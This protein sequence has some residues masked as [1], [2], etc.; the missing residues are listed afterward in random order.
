M[1]LHA[2]SSSAS[3]ATGSQPLLPSLQHEQVPRC[4]LTEMC[5]DWPRANI[6]EQWP[7]PVAAELATFHWPLRSVSE[8]RRLFECHHAAP[9]SVCGGEF[10]AAVRSENERVHREVTISADHRESLIPGVHACM[11]MRVVLNMRSRASGR[12]PW[13]RAYLFPPCTHQTL[14]DT[15]ARAA[16][17]LDGRRFWGILFVIWCWCVN[18]IMIMV[19]QPDTV[20]P[21][22]YRPPTQR[23]RTSE[24]G[25]ADDKP[26]NLYERGRAPLAPVKAV[27]GTSGH[28]R[29]RDFADAE[30]RDRWRSSWARFPHTVR[31]VVAAEHD[32]LPLATPDFEEERERFAV[33]CYR[34]G[35]HVPADYE[36]RDAQ[37]SSM[38]DRAYQSTRGLGDGR[39]PAATL[40]RS[41]REDSVLASAPADLTSMDIAALD[42]RRVDL[43]EVNPNVILLCFVIMQTTPLILA[44]LNGF[45]VIGADFR[46]ETHRSIGLAVATRWAEAAIGAA[47]STFLVGEYRDGARLFVAP[48]NFEPNPTDIVRTPTQRIRRER[49][50]RQARTGCGLAWCTL[51]A[52][53]GT[54]CYDPAA[55]VAAACSA[56]CGPVEY[57]ADAAICGHPLLTTF[58]FGAFSSRPL[59]DSPQ[60]LSV[61][62]TVPELA[63]Q[64]GWHDARLL[65]QRI[66]E[67]GTQRGDTDILYWGQA[68]RPPELQDIPHALFEGLPSFEDQRL[69]QL[70]FTPIRP[71]PRRDRL[72]IKPAQPPA[73][74]GRCPRSAADVMPPAVYRRIETWFQLALADLVCMRDE[75]VDCDRHRPPVLV[76]ARDELYPWARGHV[77]DF[78]RSPKECG[79]PLDYQSGRQPTLNADFF[80]QE[81]KDYPNQRIL[82]MIEDG[83]IYQADVEMQGVFIPHLE[84]LPKGYKAVAKELHRLNKLG[85]Y[86]FTAHIPFWPLYF[87]AQGS[88][89]RKL[90]PDRDRR[91]TEGGGPRKATFDRT[92]VQVIS[93][94][95]ASKTYHVPQHFLEDQRPEWVEWMA[96]RGLPPTPD[97]IEAL[98]WTRGTKWQRQ[99]MPDLRGVAND[100]AVLR[101]AGKLLNMPVYLFGDDVKDFFNHCENAPSELPLMNIVFLGEDD[102]LKA[103]ARQRAYSDNAGNTLIMINERRMGFGIHPNSGIAQELSESI[104]YIFRRRMDAHQDPINEADPRPAMQSW[105]AQRRQLEQRVGGHQRRLYS[106]VTFMDDNLI[107]VV[108]VEQAIAAIRIRRDITRA[109]GLIMAIPE[110][111]VLGVWGVWLG[112]AI[113]VFLGLLVV[114]KSKLVRAS[115]SVTEAL[116]DN[117]TFD[118][119]RSLMGLLEHIRH[120]TRWPKRIMHGLYRPHGPEGASR[121]GPGGIVR[122]DQFMAR[123]LMRW[124]QLLSSK[125]GAAFTAVLTRS[126]LPE[127]YGG[128]QY[129]ASSDAATDSVPPGMGGFMH[130]MCWYLALTDHV[131][132]W[133]H[134]S[135]LEMLASGFSAIIF[136]QRLGPYA[137]L[138]LG[139]DALATPYALT[140]DSQSS[141]MLVETHHA[142]LDSS[143]F[144]Q[145]APMIGIG[146]LRGDAN[147][148]SDAVSR[149]EIEVLARLAKN[150]RTRLTQL[151]FPASCQAILDRVLAYA[152]ARGQQV[153]PNPYQSSPPSVPA[154]Y[155]QYVALPAKRLHAPTSDESGLGSERS[156][157]MDG[158]GPPAADL[159][160]LAAAAG[161]AADAADD[162]FLAALDGV[163][164]GVP[165]QDMAQVRRLRTLA[166]HLNIGEAKTPTFTAM[167]AALDQIAHPQRFQRDQDFWE[168]HKASRSNFQK[169]KA[170]LQPVACRALVSRTHRPTSQESGLGKERSDRVEGDGPGKYTAAL[171][172]APLPVSAAQAGVKRSRFYLATHAP[173][174]HQ[175]PLQPPPPPK[176]QS[177]EPVRAGKQVRALPVPEERMATVVAGGQRFAAPYRRRER[178]VSARKQAMLDH[179]HQRAIAMAGPLATDEQRANLQEAVVATHEL[180]EFGAAYGT[181]DKDDHAWPYWERFCQTYGWET[182][183][184]GEFARRC[185]EE[186]T[187]RLAIFQAWVYPQLRGR[188]GRADAK[189]R[190]AFN[191]Y[192]LSIL[193]I[194]GR[195][196]VPMP[197]AK[198]VERS[199]AGLQRSFKL[200][201]G[202]EHL[203]PGRKQP[204]TPAMFARMEDLK[205]GT[206]LKGRRDAW[207]PQTRWRD[208]IIL[209]LGR[210]LW[211]TGHRLGEI[212]HHPSGE[213]NYLTRSCVSIRKA[214]GRKIAVPTVADWHAL[215]AG[216][217]VLLAPCV[218]KSDQFGE[219]HCPFPSVLPHDGTDT[220]AAASV[221]DIELEQPCAPG[222]RKTTPLFAEADGSAF[223]Y[224]VLHRELRQ[225]TSALF[226][227]SVASTL[228]WHSFRIGL[229]CA[230]HAADCP[231]GVIQLICR[232]ACPESLHVYAQMGVEKNVY[233]TEKA[234][235]TTFDATRVNNLPALDNDEVVADGM[236]LDPDSPPRPTQPRLAASFIIPGGHVQAHRSDSTGLIGIT[237]AVPR[238]FWSE[239]DLQGY[240]AATFPCVVAAECAREFRHTDGERAHTYLIEHHGQFFPIKRADLI[241]KCLTRAQRATLQL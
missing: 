98:K 85:W 105:L 10:T 41:L 150:L 27:G 54:V 33:A 205:E 182:T 125:A 235:R 158:D 185:P 63:M 20:I 239:A 67:D 219:Q 93:I 231:D 212:V 8:L 139:A 96:S 99:H 104:D 176:R 138:T 14:S 164:A 44:M 121:D 186:I 142:L 147:L 131:V 76:I 207:S 120:A 115:A 29:L 206:R 203:M 178:A 61:S 90:E 162:A 22:L 156:D 137:H 211:R 214:D 175:Q 108:G 117:S 192:V 73:P 144:N 65:Q 72:R 31:A 141:E 195:A 226:G 222:A 145:V 201:Y 148:A 237:A 166:A 102:D 184:T 36:S 157:R 3:C 92:G 160:L 28:G 143:E 173:P 19:E 43:R 183:F 171:A 13:L 221:R 24:M 124:L 103:D 35:L 224:A 133:L 9:A 135:V 232:W 57:L 189:P 123:Q 60:G 188:N 169:M 68:I 180:T 140:Q 230:L 59:V 46:Q 48:V 49:A 97:Q 38:A 74:V 50:R 154:P 197:K 240:T 6:F 126:S 127:Q 153:R 30:E 136:G 229:A 196:H 128:L 129:Y 225:V 69:D 5:G 198:A 91:T 51:A 191:N 55:R 88:T 100:F 167:T 26:I 113:F 23:L 42:G 87:N 202:V 32:G 107:G 155:Q 220:S 66:Q 17:E 58:S 236:Q 210:V 187:E 12:E 190:T 111:R 11:D 163:V 227:T 174:P 15:I 194:L 204:M 134:I 130:G 84:S 241:F 213:I 217:V 218:S 228:T 78:R 223:T 159:S 4:T 39:R 79:F 116:N 70:A 234:R 89:A 149:A 94:N 101:R 75:G 233:W 1:S 25:D 18:A 110:K 86:D 21:Q 95:D 56:L 119:Y 132:K 62:S 179:A 64:R 80:R 122:P 112:I 52:L 215:A 165:R 114:P 82:G 209:R 152:V 77:W 53:A 45:E 177:T 2:L 193:R 71:P 199:L 161:V 81:L 34:A 208:R 146:H 172:R 37:P 200:I 216:D 106:S 170:K 83:V 118:T 109:A 7:T 47:S 16:K 151:P 238:S 168:A 181:L 40:P